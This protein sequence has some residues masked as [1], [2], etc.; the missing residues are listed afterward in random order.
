MSKAKRSY[1]LLLTPTR[2]HQVGA[3]PRGDCSGLKILLSASE[4]L[5]SSRVPLFSAREQPGKPQK[6]TPEFSC[7]GGAGPVRHFREFWR[8]AG[9]LVFAS[10]KYVPCFDPCSLQ[11]RHARYSLESRLCGVH[12]Q[13][14]RA[15]SI[16]GHM[17]PFGSESARGCQAARPRALS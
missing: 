7:D 5:Q 11:S 8:S 14:P 16:V 12:G 13:D 3:D 2:K 17:L 10:K 4:R 6:L 9:A 15:V 1:D